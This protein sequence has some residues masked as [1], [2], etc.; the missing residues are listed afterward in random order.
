MTTRPQPSFQRRLLNGFF[1]SLLMAAVMSLT[2]T[3][4]NTGTAPGFL[5][6]WMR[7]FCIGFAA[8]YPTAF[9]FAPIAQRLTDRILK[10]DT[11]KPHDFVSDKNGN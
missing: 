4:V 6:R 2:M 3:L 8:A 7:A 5:F 11:Q 1:M 10:T 9:V